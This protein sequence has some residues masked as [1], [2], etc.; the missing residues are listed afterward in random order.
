VRG[1]NVQDNLLE[2]LELLIPYAAP[3]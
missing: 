2:Q 1:F 3:D